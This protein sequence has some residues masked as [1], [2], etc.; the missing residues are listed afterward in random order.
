MGRFFS[1][2]GQEEM[3]LDASRVV[4]IHDAGLQHLILEP[5][6][7]HEA[8]IVQPGQIATRSSRVIWILSVPAPP[9]AAIDDPALIEALADATRED[10][11]A[12][13]SEAGR[14]LTSELHE[15]PVAPRWLPRIPL[16]AIGT[17]GPGDDDALLWWVH[18]RDGYL[19]QA[20][21][22]WVRRQFREGF[23]IV[24]AML[25]LARFVPSPPALADSVPAWTVQPLRLTF[26][27]PHPWFGGTDLP[28]T[29]GVRVIPP[30]GAGSN[31]STELSNVHSTVFAVAREAMATA[32]PYATDDTGTPTSFSLYPLP[33]LRP[34]TLTDPESGAQTS[35]VPK[36]TGDP[37]AWAP[38]TGWISKFE[39][40]ATQTQLD[41]YAFDPG[42]WLR[43]PDP[44]MRIQSISQIG[45]HP[46]PQG[47]H[48][49][50]A[51][52]ESSP[53]PVGGVLWSS[54]WAISQGAALLP[55]QRGR[56]TAVLMGHARKV[57]ALAAL[58]ALEGLA[59]L[60]APELL[61]LC[62]WILEKRAPQG[63]AAMDEATRA[64]V[65]SAQRILDE[66]STG[67]PAP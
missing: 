36:L 26:E 10:P 54:L 55:E 16:E 32:D 20:T 29:R 31:C 64:L 58:E 63:D 23:W 66:R 19:G 17:F 22:A 3:W 50:F 56:A 44:G 62:R 59:H 65:Q 33:D 34:I 30:P 38:G 48:A 5:T 47:M 42:T 21:E 25:D 43:S 14:R 24:T 67:T 11:P 27:T 35:R 61:P 18:D 51:F 28:A 40:P 15:D 1:Q 53:P 60:D 6:L 41:L 4:V 37:D 12:G 46:T 13:L 2:D 39:F 45:W 8:P 52:L 57:D 9:E 7:S 49:L